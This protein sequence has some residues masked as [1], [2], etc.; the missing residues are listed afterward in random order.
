VSSLNLGLPR[1]NRNNLTSDLALPLAPFGWLIHSLSTTATTG[2][3]LPYPGMF[4]HSC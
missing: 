2:N 4:K 1:L 3:N